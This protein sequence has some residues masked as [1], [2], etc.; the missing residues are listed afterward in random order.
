MQQKKKGSSNNGSINVINGLFLA[1]RTAKLPDWV[2]DIWA[3]ISLNWW[4]FDLILSFNCLFPF[5]RTIISKWRRKS[6]DFRPY[7]KNFWNFEL[8]MHEGV[9]KKKTICEYNIDKRV[10]SR[11]SRWRPQLQCVD[12]NNFFFLSKSRQ[13]T[14]TCYVKPMFFKLNDFFES[15]DKQKTKKKLLL[16]LFFYFEKYMMSRNSQFL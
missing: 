13:V 3:L 15:F 9:Q 4:P 14:M 1:D 16:S 2:I 5:S 7:F 10:I 12:P 11:V 6:R 8:L